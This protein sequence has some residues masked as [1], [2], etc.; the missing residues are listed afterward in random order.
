MLIGPHPVHTPYAV[1]DDIPVRFNGGESSAAASLHIEAAVATFIGS[2]QSLSSTASVKIPPP[3]EPPRQASQEVAAKSLH[4]AASSCEVAACSCQSL[5][6]RIG[7]PR[8]REYL[9]GTGAA[10]IPHGFADPS[11]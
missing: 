3:W 11:P 8:K 9:E 4:V 10:V 1:R 2:T 5:L 6:S 7:L